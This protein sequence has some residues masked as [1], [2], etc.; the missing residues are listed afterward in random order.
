MSSYPRILHSQF[1]SLLSGY[2]PMVLYGTVHVWPFPCLLIALIMRE[3]SSSFVV[4]V[5][6]S[7]VRGGNLGRYLR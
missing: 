2:M 4:L 7:L 1:S 5:V 6:V 3:S